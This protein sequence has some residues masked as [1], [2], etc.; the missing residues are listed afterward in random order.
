MMSRLLGAADRKSYEG[1]CAK[2]AKLWC[3]FWCRF[4]PE[5]GA[6]WCDSVQHA[7]VTNTLMNTRDL[8]VSATPCRSL[9]K[10]KNGLKIRRGQP[11]GGSTP[12]PA[13]KFERLLSKTASR[14]ESRLRCWLCFPQHQRFRTQLP[15][16]R[17]SPLLLRQFSSSYRVTCAHSPRSH[18][19]E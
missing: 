9:Q 16:H 12:L 6:I 18:R 14:C 1:D 7:I 4:V 5:F 8:R 11:R 10:G 15:D 13:P 17:S 3:R 19:D 2:W